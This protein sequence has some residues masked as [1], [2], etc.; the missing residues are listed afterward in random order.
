MLLHKLISEVFNE[1]P[2][3]HSIQK[4]LVIFGKDCYV[5]KGSSSHLPA[6]LVGFGFLVVV[7]P[8]IILFLDFDGFASIAHHTLN[9]EVQKVRHKLIEWIILGIEELS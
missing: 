4:V 7:L 3:S 5:V 1:I 9:V 8:I 6:L 2:F